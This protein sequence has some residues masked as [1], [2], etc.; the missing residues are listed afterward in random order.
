MLR[1]NNDIRQEGIYE[2]FFDGY[3]KALVAKTK[4]LGDPE[5]MATGIG[6][7]VD[8]AQFDRVSGFISRGKS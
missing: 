3:I 7:L 2:R 8:K 4:S 1:C 6:P 5:I